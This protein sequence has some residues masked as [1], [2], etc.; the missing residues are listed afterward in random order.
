MD[1]TGF[2]GRVRRFDRNRILEAAARARLRRRRR[3]AIQL[4]RWVLAVEPRNIELHAVLAPLLA[5]TGQY[6]DAWISYRTVARACQRRGEVEKALAVY[7]EAARYMPRELQAWNAIAALEHRSGRTREAIDTLVEGARH[8]RSRWRR[9]QA[10]LL[11]RRARELDSWNFETVLELARLLS[12]S[13]QAEEAWLLLQGLAVRSEGEA[14]RRVRGAQFCIAP[15]LRQAWLW[16]R[17]VVHSERPP[18]PR[19]RPAC[20]RADP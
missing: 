10:I 2:F 17:A 13:E 19:S 4:Y 5:E 9:P 3:R 18:E 11:L 16:L 6:F 14:L 8:F 12:G 15:G 7:R 1:G 20:S